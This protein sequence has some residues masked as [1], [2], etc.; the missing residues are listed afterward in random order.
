MS[1]DRVLFVFDRFERL[2][3]VLQSHGYAI[4]PGPRDPSE[5]QELHWEDPPTGLVRLKGVRLRDLDDPDADFDPDITFS[6]Q[7]FWSPTHV[8][9]A[10]AERGLYLVG[11][12]YHA[13]YRGVDQRWDFDPAGHPEMPYHHH[14][15]GVPERRPMTGHITPEHALDAFADWITSQIT[16]S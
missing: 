4:D 13:H 10:E 9:H 7:E 11:Y 12:S 6:I 14:P 15:P 2:V 16:T 8:D 5:W 1:R 3:E